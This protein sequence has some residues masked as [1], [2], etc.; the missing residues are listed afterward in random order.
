[1]YWIYV[2]TRVVSLNIDEREKVPLIGVDGRGH[3]A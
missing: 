3:W 2:L 1:M